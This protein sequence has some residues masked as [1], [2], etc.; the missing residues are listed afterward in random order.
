MTIF[1]LADYNVAFLTYFTFTC[2][3]TVVASVWWLKTVDHPHTAVM[4]SKHPE[5][6]LADVSADLRNEQDWKL[7]SLRILDFP[8]NVTALAVEPIIGLL[9]VGMY[10]LTFLVIPYWTSDKVH[11]V[12][13][14]TSLAVQELSLSWHCRDRWRY[15]LCISRHQH[16]TLSVLVRGILLVYM[17]GLILSSDDSNNLHVWDLLSF[18]R[19]KLVASA[20]FDQTKYDYLV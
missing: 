11:P 17:S 9:A 6:V 10:L 20:H 15:A 13:P 2:I 3:S 16:V 4:F 12:G 7:G 1:F 14:S 5:H 18:G 19:P 8:L